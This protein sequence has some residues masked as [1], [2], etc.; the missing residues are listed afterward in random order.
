MFN[1]ARIIFCPEHMV[2]FINI[3]HQLSHFVWQAL[4]EISAFMSG[5]RQYTFRETRVRTEKFANYDLNLCIYDF[6]Y[7]HMKKNPLDN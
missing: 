7:S 4:S 6:L 2:Y 3:Q 1:N 5:G